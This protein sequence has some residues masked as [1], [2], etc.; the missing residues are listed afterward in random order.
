M[1][2]TCGKF[3]FDTSRPIIMGVLNVTPDSFS[4]GGS[5]NTPE[6]AIKHAKDMLNA[7]AL[8]IDVGGESTRPGSVEVAP[9][10]ELARVLPVV[11]ALAAQG[12]CVSIDTRHA[13]VAK[14]CLAVG[15][16]IIN[17]VSGFRSTEMVDVVKDNDCGVVVVHC[18]GEV[19]APIKNPT[20]TDVVAEVKKYLKQ[21][22]QMLERAGI[23]ASR[24]CIDPGPG[25]GKTPQ[26]TLELVR[27]MHEFCRLGLPVMAALSRKSYIG[28]AYGIEMPCE[29]DDA[30][31][32][33]ALQ[34]CELGCGVVRCHNVEKTQEAL[35]GL[36]PYV[37]LGLGCN[38]A[39]VANDD[40]LTEGKIAVL[41][42][43]IG[44]LCMLPDTQIVDISSFYESEPAYYENQDAFINAI[45]LLRTGI[46]PGELLG[47]L[48][49]IENNLGRTRTVENG[50]RT[51]D[52]DILDYQLYACES[53]TLTLPHPRILE[54]DFVVKPLLELRPSHML[55]NGVSVAS[56]CEPECKRV[57]AATK[58]TS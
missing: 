21:Q 31:A 29:R 13:Q 12:A 30:S 25:F 45:V 11:K 47:Y 43:A 3:K 39:L 36:H 46:A 27:N 35:Q 49:A 28:T 6:L 20:Y 7:G 50:P 9:E 44:Q 40:E 24:I 53:E 14:A 17:D 22:V 10:V 52:I 19:G 8:I 1:I 18:K 41:N 55:A 32:K 54:R 5:L 51:C 16:A 56:A 23:D 33:E 42:N 57:G 37:L 34:A 2:W 58:L 4:D 48:H 38:V 15:A 26:Q